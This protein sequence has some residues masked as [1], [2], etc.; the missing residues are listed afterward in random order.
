MMKKLLASGIALALFVSVVPGVASAQTSTTTATTQIQT[1]LQQIRQ[2]Q[3]QLA[4]LTKQRGETVTE[5]KSAL[6][7]AREL[8]QGMSGEDVTALQEL[9]AADPDIYPEGIV[10]GF[11]GPLTTKAVRKFQQKNGLETVGNVGPKT[12]ARLNALAGDATFACRAWGKLI[13]PGQLKRLVGSASIDLSHCAKVPEGIAKK[14][15]GDWKTG[16]STASTTDTTAPVISDIDVDDITDDGATLTW[17]TNERANAVVWYGTD[18]DVDLDDAEKETV[19]DFER[20]QELVL[21]GLDNA[22]DYYFIVVATDKAGNTATSS[23]E[24]FETDV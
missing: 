9:L 23:V 6:V 13:A 5:L 19:S 4:A 22:T 14:L 24:D 11:F 10:S 3:D 7:L 1:L 20:E 8:R 2:L 12:R 18:E 16:T 17:E 15:S 21:D